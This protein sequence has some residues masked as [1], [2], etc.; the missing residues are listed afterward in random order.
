MFISTGM[1]NYKH[2]LLE[3]IN[4]FEYY[5]LYKAELETWIKSVLEHDN[6]AA[7]WQNLPLLE[8]IGTRIDDNHFVVFDYYMCVD[9]NTKLMKTYKETIFSYYCKGKQKNDYADR[10]SSF[11]YKY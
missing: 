11:I 4:E 1:K 3:Y 2:N 5:H 7:D 9:D 10:I 8:F 6:F